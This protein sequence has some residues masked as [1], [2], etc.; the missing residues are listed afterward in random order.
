MLYPLR[1]ARARISASIRAPVLDNSILSKISLL[2]NLKAQS[3]SRIFRPNIR[4]TSLQRSSVTKI[5]FMMHHF[6]PAVSSR[7]LIGDSPGTVGTAVVNYN[8]LKIS[9]ELLHDLKCLFNGP[10]NIF[11][12]VV[13]REKNAD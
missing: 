12:L 1:A 4:Q 13:T 8:Y 6:Y 9:V 3:M 2:Y 10:A 11:L 5:T 7:N